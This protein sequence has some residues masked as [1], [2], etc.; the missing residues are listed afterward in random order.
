MADAAGGAVDQEVV[1]GLELDRVDDDLPGG[2]P[3][4]RQRPCL[5]VRQRV[6]LGGEVARRGGY[7]LGVGAGLAREPGHAEDFLADLEAGDAGADSGDDAADVPAD[8]EG[9][10]AEDAGHPLARAGLEVDR[11]DPGGPNLD[12]DLGRDRLRRLDLG[13]GQHL[14]PAELV[15]D[16]RPHRPIIGA[17]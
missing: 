2:Q 10:L 5:Q 1:A 6:R 11:V 3:G 9:R 15:L 17:L 7:V 13:Q 16:D 4:Q 8:G 14:R 12:L